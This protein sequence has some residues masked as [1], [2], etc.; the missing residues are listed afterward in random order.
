MQALAFEPDPHADRQEQ[1]Q[2]GVQAHR[3][4]QPEYGRVFCADLC[5]SVQRPDCGVSVGCGEPSCSGALCPHTPPASTAGP[6]HPV[7]S[8]MEV[9]QSAGQPPPDSAR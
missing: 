7:W 5:D 2:Q 3:G 4:L 6:H 8:K 9:L 1:P